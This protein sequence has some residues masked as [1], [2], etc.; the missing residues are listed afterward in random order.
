MPRRGIRVELS[1]YLSDLEP[2]ALKGLVSAPIAYR[3]D[4][5]L[6]VLKDARPLGAVTPAELVSALLHATPPDLD[7]LR[8]KV[9]AYRNARVWQT[10]EGPR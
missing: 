3:I 6:D 1:E 8:M 10:R 2:K 9:E 5:L 4:R 7:D